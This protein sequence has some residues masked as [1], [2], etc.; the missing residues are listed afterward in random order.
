MPLKSGNKKP[1]KKYRQIEILNNSS[2]DVIKKAIESQYRY[3]IIGYIVGVV[4]IL[5]GAVLLVLK[6]FFPQ[7]D[8]SFKILSFSIS[9]NN[10]SPGIILFIIGLIII[11]IT[12]FSVKTKR[13]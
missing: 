7:N 4:I 10:A 13:N 12:R 6:I 5:L 1:D 3:S 9:T 2:D 11:Y 8:I